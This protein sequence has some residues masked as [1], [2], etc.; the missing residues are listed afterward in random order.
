MMKFCT[1]IFYKVIG[2]PFLLAS[3]FN[4][5]YIIS[6]RYLWSKNNI[7]EFIFEVQEGSYF[8]L[9]IKNSIVLQSLILWLYLIE[10]IKRLKR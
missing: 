1:A 2:I 5:E 9:T 10:R 8:V 6:T 3:E 7:A 4:H